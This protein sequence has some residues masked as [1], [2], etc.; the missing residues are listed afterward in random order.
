MDRPGELS[1]C[2]LLGEGPRGR[3]KV[4][5]QLCE[6]VCPPRY[7]ITSPGPTVNPEVIME[8]PR[9]LRSICCDVFSVAIA[10]RARKKLFLDEGLLLDRSIQR[11]TGSR[12]SPSFELGGFI[13][14]PS[15]MEKRRKT[16][17]LRPGHEGKVDWYGRSVFY[18]SALTI[19]F[20]F[21][22]VANPLSK[23]PESD[24]FGAHHHFPGGSFRDAACILPAAV[25][26]L[27]YAGAVWTGLFVIMLLNIEEAEKKRIH[28]FS[29]VWGNCCFGSHLCSWFGD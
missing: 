23:N 28:V 8:R 18:I 10:R 6:F 13:K 1:R 22:V 7:S 16:P 2:P 20:G 27:V 17:R 21:L 19:F 4:S 14:I 11:R 15:R 24:V 5:C 29:W 12:Q 3:T 9:E 25:Q 26:I